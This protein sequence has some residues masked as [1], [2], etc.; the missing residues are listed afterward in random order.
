M[1]KVSVVIPALNEEKTV[2]ICV[3]KAKN[4]CE[5][6]GIP[7]EV[8]VVDNGSSDKTAEVASEKGAKVVYEEMQGYGAAL[9]KGFKEAKGDYIIMGDADD[10]Y[11]FNEI[12]KFVEK[13]DEGY[14]LVIGS[15][16][17]GGIEKGAMPWHHKYIGNPILTCILNI[18]FKA[19][20]SD[21]HSGMRG[22]R[23]ELIERLN[24]RTT[25]MEFASEMIVKAIQIG[26]KIAEVPIVLHKDKRGRR[27]HL[28]SFPDAWRHLRFMLLFTPL[29]LFLIPGVLL[30][31]IGLIIV[32]VLVWGPLQVGPKILGYHTLIFGSM[33]AILG[34]QIIIQ[35]LT[36]RAY[37]ISRNLLSQPTFMDRIAMDFTLEKGLIF[38]SILL[39]I[40]IVPILKIFITW[41][42]QN[43]SKVEITSLRPAI[44]GLTFLTLGVQTVFSSF[45]IS[46]FK[47]KSIY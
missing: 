42:L 9:L 41:I 13:L 45:F 11:D 24:L 33:M 25:G 38:G 29:N 43:F 46:S 23:R 19:R 14:D 21:A 20:I 47:I 7:Y 39:L 2:G 27:S 17:K 40:G 31:V 28:R 8:I 16:F 4:A 34:Y 32:C 37:A 6:L 15:R 35:G 22:F 44:F 30:T 10:S 36:I 5:N 3:E 18:L 1:I 26:A 12:P